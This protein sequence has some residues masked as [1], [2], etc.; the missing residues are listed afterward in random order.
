MHN[1]FLTLALTLSFLCANVSAQENNR[2]TMKAYMVANA[3]LDT[4]WN[5]DYR[6]TIKEY[7][8]KT[9]RQNLFLFKKYPDYIF[10]FEGAVKYSWMKEYYPLEF[11]EVKKYVA[12]GRWHLAGGSWDANETIVCSPESWM[13]NILLGQTFYR[14]EFSRES[15]DAFLPDCFGFG[16]DLPTLASHCGLIGFSSQKLAWR[17]HP[18][19]D[20]GR[21]FPFTVGLWQGID[22]SRIMAVHG[23]YYDAKWNDVDLSN[24]EVL[25]KE[26]A[27][28]PL[29][30]VYRYYGVGDM[31]GS[32][33]IPSVRSVEKGIKGIGPIEV[34]SAASDRLYRDLLTNNKLS[35]LPIFDGEL[36]MDVH[37]SGCYTSQAAMKLYNR[38]NEHLG[39]AAERAAVTAEWLGTSVYP[40]AELTDCWRRII[41]HQFHDDLSGTCRPSNYEV[42]W[43]DELLS[44]SRFSKVL[45]TSVNGIASYMNTNVSGVPVVLYNA[46]A[47][48]VR[49]VAEVVLP[50]MA[51]EYIVTDTDGKRVNTQ[52]GINSKVDRR[53]LFEADVPAAGAKVYSVK[54]VNKKEYVKTKDVRTIENSV[55]ALTVDDDGNI[56][57]IFDKRNNKE[58]VAKGKAVSL[59]VFDDCKSYAWPA[60]EIHKTTID[61]EPVKVKDNVQ[62]TLLEEGPIRKSLL[63]SRTY[64]TSRFDQYIRLYEGSLA[65]RIDI[66]NEVYWDSENAFLKA[67]FPLNVSNAKATYDLGLGSIQ[68][69]NNQANAY[70]VPAHEWTDLTDADGSYGV[71]IMNDCKY[72][73]D[74]PDDNTLRM[75]LLYTPKTDRTFVYQ[76][77]QDL[78]FHAF[79]YSIVGHQG[80]LNRAQ[81]VQKS[82]LLN[83]PLKAFLSL[84]HGGALGKSFSFIS[85]DNDNVTVR[86][87]KRAEVSDEYVVRVYENSGEA[88]QNAHLTFAANIVKAVEADGTEKEK[89]AA[90]FQGNKLNVTVN[91]FGVKTYK[92]VLN[93][94]YSS[95]LPVAEPLSLPYD[96]KCFSFNGFRNAANFEGG[97]SYAAELLPDSGIVVDDIPFKFGEKDAANGLVCKG[98]VLRLPKGKTYN[99]LY[100]LAASTKGDRRVTFVAGKNKQTALVPY[101]TGFIGQWGHKGHTHGYLKDAEV[102]YIG[103]HRHSPS[104]DE[105]YEYTYM[106]KLGID[107]P[108]GATQIVLPQDDKVVVF[109]ATLA[110]ENAPITPACRL[111]NTGNKTNDFEDT[112]HERINLMRDAKVIDCSGEINTE[113]V[114][115]NLIDGNMDTKWRDMTDAPNYV[116]FDLGKEQTVSGWKLMNAGRESPTYITGGCTLQGRN[117]MQGEWETLDKM[118]NNRSDEPERS[119]TPAKVRYVRLLVSNPTQVADHDAVRIYEF[120]LY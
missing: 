88:I 11:E 69:G 35:A 33:D 36:L 22:G 8:P 82:T 14:Q 18:F 62:V 78:G 51:G 97:Y 87:V 57:S 111:F 64:G 25:K 3:H 61:K 85:S 9:I 72:G 112:V 53:L 19:Y 74:K 17:S 45:T 44:L 34:I 63:V 120:E 91:P 81:A 68:R 107:I 37:G 118:E 115:A 95:A 24:D 2:K 16:Y 27:E 94:T 1:K 55:Y 60:W 101:Y 99:K 77:Q 49:T 40:S 28:S 20:T 117:S 84:K 103:T 86:A 39:D 6:T 96:R 56:S 30:M 73:W 7:I 4:Q 114:A 93:R 71:T 119:F 42:S 102:A 13:R 65:D 38:Q 98:N 32:P 116:V 43:N 92:V 106:F 109:A 50:Q 41:L 66:Y 59:V 110:E 26:I 70:E 67:Q 54:A 89:G 15:T 21:K 23:F 58:L 75:S 52:V 5:W 100:V 90:S 47:F 80:E 113:D 108:K 79:T 104:A 83:S 12:N 105:P 29:N 76:G 48:P 46:E 31:G 10:N